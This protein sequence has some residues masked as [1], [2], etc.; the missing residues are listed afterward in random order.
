MSEKNFAARTKNAFKF[1]VVYSDSS[2]TGIDLTN[3]NI[4]M[5][6]KKSDGTAVA[7]LTSS[8]AAGITKANQTTNPGQF[9]V[10]VGK[11][12]TTTWPVE[13]LYYDLQLVSTGNA[14][15]VE[16]IMWGKVVVTSGVTD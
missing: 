8:P 1:T 9:S 14:E 7:D 6:I 4:K 11:T 13:D 16:S 10:F 5:D 15:D 12:A 3:Y 2:D